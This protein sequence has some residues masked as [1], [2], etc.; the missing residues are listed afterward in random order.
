MCPGYKDSS[1]LIFRSYKG[2]KYD[3]FSTAI[4]YSR[5]QSSPP[6]TEFIQNDNDMLIE[7]RALAQ[8]YKEFCVVASDRSLS[9]GFLDGL[10][11]LIAHAGECSDIAHAAKSVVLACIGNQ[12][13]RQSLLDRSKHL[14]N[15]VI[16][17]FRL[18]LSNANTSNTMESL[19]TAV[20]LGLHEVM[21][22]LDA[23]RQL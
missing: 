19:M 2:H 23:F 6:T 22:W 3:L 7:S 11:G 14:Y 4:S 20:L 13:G 12:L 17:S 16:S 8:F 10:E 15:N 9:R 21:Y 1:D 18:T 5:I